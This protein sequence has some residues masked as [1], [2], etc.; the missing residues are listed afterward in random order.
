MFIAGSTLS[1][2][3]STLV[4]FAITWHIVLLTES[5]FMLMLSTV[6]GFLPQL[7]I[8]LPAGA[9]ADRFNKKT[10]II[11]ADASLVVTAGVLAVLFMAGHDYIWLLFV[12]SVV[13]SAGIGVRGPAVL[14]IIPNIVPAEHLARV[15]GIRASLRGITGLVAPALAGG[16]YATIGIHA[17]FIG[18]VVSGGMGILLL[19]FITISW[20]KTPESPGMWES[21][22][23]G[24]KYI[25]ITP[26]LK[27]FFIIFIATTLMIGPAAFLSPLLIV[28]NFG[29][30]PFFLAAHG[31][32]MSTGSIAGGFVTGWIAGKFANKIRLTMVMFLL[33]GLVIFSLGFAG[34]FWLFIGIAALLGATVS[35]MNAAIITALQTYTDPNYIG[36]V[37]SF[38]W[39]V[40]GAAIPISMMIFGPIA[41]IVPVEWLIIISGG[42]IAVIS[43]LGVRLNAWKSFDRQADTHEKT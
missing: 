35:L 41:D 10:L 4:Q 21:M 14:S 6:F 31:M 7:L 23:G 38:T 8:S 9:W 36:R 42:A 3:G 13:R 12:I 43:L 2:L 29:D 27:L 19:F 16:L 17:L 1:G 5:G 11:L 32:S 39:L 24:V 34:V 37:F 15:N 28:R 20:R 30:E 40:D 33:W 26:W 22:V 18:D 25:F